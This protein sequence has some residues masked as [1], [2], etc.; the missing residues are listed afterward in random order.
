MAKKKPDIYSNKQRWKVLLLIL[1]LLIVGGSLILSNVMVAKISEK[2]TYKA[3]QWA[4]A[5]QKKAEWVR[6]SHEIFT[7]LSERERQRI[8]MVVDA[9]KAI[10]NPSSLNMNQDIDFALSIINGNNDI[11]VVLLDDLGKVSLYKN[12]DFGTDSVKILKNISLRDS[13]L[14][15]NAREWKAKQRFFELAVFEDFKMTYAYDESKK[16]KHLKHQSDSILKAFNQELIA[17][18][19]LMPVILVDAKKEHILASNLKDTKEPLSVY[20]KKF[21]SM[22]APIKID[23]GNKNTHWLY[24]DQSPEVKQLRWFPYIQ[25]SMIAI[26]VLIGYLVFSTFRRAEQNQVWAGMAKETA[27][28]LGTPL[29][30]LVAWVDLLESKDTDPES[31]EEMRKDLSRL[32]KVTDRFSKIGSETKLESL[33]I[34][35]TVTEILSYLKIRLSNKVVIEIDAKEQGLLVP[36]NAALIEW[37]IENITKNAVDAMGGSGR[38]SV[39]IV[40]NTHWIHIDLSDTGKGLTPKQFKTVFQPGYSTK[41]RGWGLGLSLAKRIIE[42]YHKGK[43]LVLKSEINK[44]TVFRISLPL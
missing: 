15:S 36:H 6:F 11:P 7:S 28:Q 40:Q 38:F 19:R 44:G 4:H 1:A 26:V 31:L 33:D 29:S 34:V 5:I 41:K 27:H 43:I 22:N 21:K 16:L 14:T 20:L 18:A 2:E 13:I 37:V 10:L 24:Y 39:S 25:F 17:D 35:R 8:Q 32:G 30:S 42:D 3:K 9:Q 12:I 23:L